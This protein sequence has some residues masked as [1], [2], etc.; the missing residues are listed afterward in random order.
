MSQAGTVSQATTPPPER[1]IAP[2]GNPVFRAIWLATVVSN[3][4]GWVHDVAAGWLM[5]S[6]SPSPLMV[7]L[8]QAAT[9]LPVFLLSIPAGALADVVDRRRLLL[10]TQIW[11]MLGAAALGL[12]TAQGWTTAVTLLVLTFLIETGSAASGPAWQAVTA[13]LVPKNLLRS[14]VTLNGLGINVARAVGPAIGGIL[15]AW[16]GPPTA[17]L[18]NAASFLAVAGVLL[19][20]RRVRETNALPTERFFGAIKAGVRYA[21]HAPGVQVVLLRTASFMIGASAIWALLPTIARVHLGL[22]PGGYGMLLGCMGT[23]ALIGAVLLGR[24]RQRLS[25]DRL[26]VAATA[27]FAAATA[28]AGLVPSFPAACAAMIAAGAGWVLVVANLNASAQAAVPDWV[29]ARV[30][31]V[32]LV[33]FYGGM[34]GG[35]VL[36]GALAARTSLPTALVSAAVVLLG[37]TAMALRFRLAQVESADLAP[38]MHWDDPIVAREANLDDGPVMITVALD[39]DLKRE[40]EFIDLMQQV[41]LERLRDGAFQW[42]LFHDT[43]RPGHFVETF[44]VESW[45]EHLRQHRRVTHSDKTIED[46]ARAFHIGPQPLVISH[47]IYARKPPP[48]GPG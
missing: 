24:I 32:Y 7:S 46:Q 2:L 5:T 33:V 18:I 12:L 20:W 29:R 34:A 22:G 4:G 35:S 47:L 28:T 31:S 42:G 23:G 25:T 11:M 8:V 14:A 39:I 30:M 10:A 19:R 38:S 6:L 1:L 45:A 27:L 16:A 41:R 37:G 3:I 44:F 26:V 17:F 43:A 40:A 9:S 36:W 48:D 13:E 15:V 21:S